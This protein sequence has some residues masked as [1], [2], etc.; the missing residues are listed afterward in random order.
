M[1]IKST[2]IIDFNNSI[3]KETYNKRYHVLLLLMMIGGI[4]GG[5][6][7]QTVNF[8]VN[9]EI[10]QK[11]NEFVTINQDKSF[12]ELFFADFLYNLIFLLLPLFLGVS[13]IG[14][15][16]I[17]FVPFVKGLGIGTVCALIYSLYGL[18][19][20]GYCAIIIYPIALIQLFV[21]VLSCNEAYLMSSEIFSVLIKRNTAEEIRISLF[22]LRYLII[23]I[24]LSFSSVIYAVCNMVF[25]KIMS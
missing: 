6:I 19:G 4:V 13:A 10:S 12:F 11:F 8:S 25:F 14:Y 18:R 17:Y 3:F 15:V 20:I 2:G 1:K 7:L 23:L 24:I 5:V 16:L 21:I 9:Q 22:F